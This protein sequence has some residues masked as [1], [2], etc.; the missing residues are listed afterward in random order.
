MTK[1][2]DSTPTAG[3]V[4]SPQRAVRFNDTDNMGSLAKDKTS[5][6]T[7]RRVL[8]EFSDAIIGYEETGVWPDNY[9]LRQWALLGRFALNAEDADREYENGRALDS[10]A[11]TQRSGE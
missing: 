7:V 11:N 10:L 5:S 3:A 4:G 2:T 6:E 1:T 9:H 8:R